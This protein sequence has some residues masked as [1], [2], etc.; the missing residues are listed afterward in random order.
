MPL[1]QT[2][3][4]GVRLIKRLQQFVPD[5]LPVVRKPAGTADN[6]T[7][8]IMGSSTA[9]LPD[10]RI[11]Y[12]PDNSGGNM[13]ILTVIWRMT[14]KAILL[15]RKKLRTQPT[16]RFVLCVLWM[17]VNTSAGNDGQPPW[18]EHDQ[19]TVAEKICCDVPGLTRQRK[20]PVVC[21]CRHD[22]S[23]LYGEGE[24]VVLCD[25]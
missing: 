17:P 8:I 23:G 11:Q 7:T 15:R 12:S 21:I 1:C 25:V 3:T 13:R 14:A 2:G 9:Q 22:G 18:F 4:Q 24:K 16:G 6:V 5:A 19:M 10:R 20:R